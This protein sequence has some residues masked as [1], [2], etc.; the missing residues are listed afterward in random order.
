MFFYD[1][2]LIGSSQIITIMP[3]RQM[4]IAGNWKMFKTST[5]AKEF[6]HAFHKLLPQWSS[7]EVVLAPSYTSIPVL[8]SELPSYV[9]IGAQNMHYEAEGAF[10][11][12]ESASMLKDV[13]VQF[14]II[15]H[16]ERRTLFQ[17]KDEAIHLKVKTALSSHLFPI[18]CIGETLSERQQ[19]L[20]EKTLER[21]ILKGLEGVSAQSF[22][23]L[24]IAYE[25]VWAIG[26]GV[27][28]SPEEAQAVHHFCRKVIA[29]H[30]G[31]E[32]ATNVRII[33]G[34]SVKLSNA[35]HLLIQPDID[36]A[37]IGGASLHAEEWAEIIKLTQQVVA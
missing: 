10:T 11:G 34:G 26:T 22:S 25:P 21:Q 3:K 29:S 23:H 6:A 33:Y 32:A 16:S 17:E 7:C 36:G 19:G 1:V 27:A 30:F 31:K 9:K 13:G 14:V 18:F 8:A 24:A 2:I 12:E 4:I 35:Y 15:G 28:A 20:T 37:L 5:Q